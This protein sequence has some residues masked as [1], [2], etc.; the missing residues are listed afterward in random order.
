MENAGERYLAKA[1]RILRRGD[2]MA[3][4]AFIAGIITGLILCCIV[5]IGCSDEDEEQDDINE[6]NTDG[7]RQ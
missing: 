2:E 1:E 4:I 6:E 5:V 3:S 7:E